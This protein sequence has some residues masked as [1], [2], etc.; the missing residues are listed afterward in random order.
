MEHLRRVVKDR[1]HIAEQ[2]RAS[3]SEL[4]GLAN[5]RHGS[6]HCS[7]T[8]DK[9][10]AKV[11]RLQRKVCLGGLPRACMYCPAGLR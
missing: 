5:S 2:F 8:L 7:Q 10:I 6:A 11:Q 4:R 1:K 3:G 9:I